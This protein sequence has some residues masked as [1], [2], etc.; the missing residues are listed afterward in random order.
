MSL[1]ESLQTD[2]T[3]FLTDIGYYDK[4]MESLEEMVTQITLQHGKTSERLA[5]PLYNIVFL[6][7]RKALQYV[8]RTSDGYKRC[9]RLGKKYASLC[10][11]VHKRY[12]K[13]Q[14]KLGRVF[15]VCGYFKGTEVLEEAQ[16]IFDASCDRQGLAQI[17]YMLGE[18]KQYDTDMNVPLALYTK[19]LD[20]CLSCFGKFHLDTAR[21]NQLFGQLYWN[22]WVY[23]E[24]RI[25]WLEKCLELYMQELEILTD[26]LGHH[27]VTTV[28]SREDVIIILQSLKREEE[29]EKYR[30]QQPA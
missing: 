1:E 12:C 9:F 2:V 7:Y 29:A 3:W 23:N 21:C 14:K 20:L 11:K 26:F 28:R 25:D 30:A 6:L 22:R 13:D 27:H 15:A 5:E 16:A 24:D 8:Y 10:Y 19:S 18:S 4:A 17:L